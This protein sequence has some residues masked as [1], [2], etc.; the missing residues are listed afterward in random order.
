MPSWMRMEKICTNI[1][2]DG[3]FPDFLSQKMRMGNVALVLGFHRLHSEDEFG[4]P[5]GPRCDTWTY[6]HALLNHHA[7]GARQII[8]RHREYNVRTTV[9]GA[10]AGHTDG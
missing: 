8:G 6:R 2:T 4:S 9:I 5:V 7:G 10:D 3:A 1:Q